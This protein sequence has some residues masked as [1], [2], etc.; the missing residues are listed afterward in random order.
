MSDCR[1]GGP[2]LVPSKVKVLFT[3]AATALPEATAAA[4]WRRRMIARMQQLI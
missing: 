3:A 4:N 1:G 2:I